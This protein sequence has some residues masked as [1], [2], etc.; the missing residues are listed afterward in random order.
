MLRTPH[1]LPNG[2]RHHN[3]R[4]VAII[5]NFAANYKTSSHLSTAWDASSTHSQPAK[6]ARP[7]NR[8][9][10]PAC[11]SQDTRAVDRRTASAL[12]PL[13]AGRHRHR[14]K[15]RI[16]II[17]SNLESR[18]L[19]RRGRASGRL[20][21]RH[22]PWI[23]VGVTG[24]LRRRF[25]ITVSKLGATTAI[26]KI[27]RYLSILQCNSSRRY[28][29]A[30]RPTGAHRYLPGGRDVD[31]EPATLGDASRIRVWSG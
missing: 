20:D 10:A 14:A 5:G 3:R 19:I 25:R 17:R 30:P 6:S 22:Y 13:P 18:V 2:T 21:N 7:S 4:S 12:N 24:A 27:W 26:A 31:A 1:A 16:A 23:F 11:R 29:S 15:A 9:S 8:F 28:N